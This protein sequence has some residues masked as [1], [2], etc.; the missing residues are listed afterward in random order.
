MRWKSVSIRPGEET[1]IQ[2][3]FN[4]RLLIDIDLRQRTLKKMSQLSFYCEVPLNQPSALRVLSLMMK[5]ISSMGSFHKQLA[6][7]P[8]SV[9]QIM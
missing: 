1:G 7:L 4:F 9:A 8:V 2:S 3:R 5:S 6:P